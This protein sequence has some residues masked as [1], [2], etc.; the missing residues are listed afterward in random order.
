MSGGPHDRL[1][2]IKA[3]WSGAAPEGLSKAARV[4]H[5][6]ARADVLWLVAEVERLR[7]ASPPEI[8][9][10]NCRWQRTTIGQCEYRETHNYCPHPEHACDCRGETWSCEC[11]HTREDHDAEGRCCVLGPS[12]VCDNPTLLRG[13]SQPGEAPIV[14][15]AGRAVEE[16]N[17]ALRQVRDALW[18]VNEGQS[19]EI[20]RLIAMLP[21][22][23]LWGRPEPEG[24]RLTEMFAALVDD[25]AEVLG[26]FT[27]PVHPGE[28]SW[29][30]GFMYD[31]H[32][33]VFYERL[34][35]YRAALRDAPPQERDCQNPEGFCEA[36]P[37]P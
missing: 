8:H 2:E 22:T 29:E 37:T 3:A 21:D 31:R 5:V 35:K 20:Q 9:T 16:E 11:E 28:S 27:R 32:R 25:F 23:A 26:Y 13:A 30:A 10:A 24:G 6:F 15:G 12:C 34:A 33:K 18:A 36:E 1:A 14:P 4:E 19:R 17:A 7:A